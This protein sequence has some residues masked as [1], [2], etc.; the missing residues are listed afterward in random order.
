MTDLAKTIAVATGSVSA[1]YRVERRNPDGTLTVVSA[2]SY[3]RR[4][5]DRISAQVAVEAV[6][7]NREDYEEETRLAVLAV[8][9]REGVADLY[10]DL[11]R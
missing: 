2:E 3:T 11:I 1:T 7:N 4:S 9:E 5:I 6:A 10:L 8:G